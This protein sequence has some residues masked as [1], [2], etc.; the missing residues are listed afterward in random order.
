MPWTKDISHELPATGGRVVTL[1]TVDGVPWVHYAVTDTGGEGHRKS[2]TLAA[3]LAADPTIDAAG[4]ATIQ[5]KFR[6]VFD[7]ALGFVNA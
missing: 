6:A 3:V 2:L 4:L 1:E 7:A 5:A